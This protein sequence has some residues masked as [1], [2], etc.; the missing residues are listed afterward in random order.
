MSEQAEPQVSQILPL[1]LVDKCIGSKILVLVKSKVE[2]TGTLV[3]FDDFVNMV[4][5]DV[6]EVNT[7]TGKETK[8]SK[9]LLSGKSIY[10]VSGVGYGEMEMEANTA[11][12]DKT[13]A[14]SSLEDFK[15]IIE[16][17]IL[18]DWTGVA[19]WFGG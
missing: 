1:E 11:Q 2:F 14:S 15:C 13:N 9:L 10:M 18:D 19:V 12:E 16:I 3:G 6:T 5:E 7:K 8:H 17:M 4:L